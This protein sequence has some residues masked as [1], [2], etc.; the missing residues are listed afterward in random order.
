M[1]QRAFGRT[2]LKVSALGYG[3]GAVGGLMVRGTAA[4]QERSLARARDAGITYVDTAAAYGDGQSETNLGRALKAIGWNPTLGTKVR[5]LPGHRG[6]IAASVAASIDAS[7]KRLGRDSVDLFQ[8]HDAI[9]SPDGFSLDEVMQQVVPAFQK[10]R[11]QGKTRFLGI[12]ALG[13]NEGLR[14]ALDSGVFDTAQIVFNALNPSWLAPKPP[15]LPGQDYA[16]LGTKTPV[17]KIGIRILAAGALSGDP[18]RH[19]IAMPSVAPIASADDYDVDLANARK[20]LPLVQEGVAGSLAELA[21][22]FAGY[23]PGMHC[24]LVGTA[25]IE[26]LEAA[27]AAVAKGPLPAA[28]LARIPALLA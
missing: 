27:L 8:L 7:L 5:L 16:L 2:G 12:T 25:S 20:L 19:P 6:S 10:A 9:G 24:A 11:E 28:A 26:Q 3:A 23:G 13:S 14:A 17:G 4:E 18:A 22:R 1:E 15:G 21:T